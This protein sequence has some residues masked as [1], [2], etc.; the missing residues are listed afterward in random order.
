MMFTKEE[1][2]W[3]DN[4]SIYALLYKW[5]FSPSG[6][7]YFQNKERADYHLKVMN[8]KRDKDNA[9]YV[10]ASKSMGW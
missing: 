9:A 8:E 4:A 10:S 7:M 5:R 6:D 2:S 3:I 1:K